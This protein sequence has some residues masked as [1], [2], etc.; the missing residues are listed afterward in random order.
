MGIRHTMCV[1]YAFCIVI[2]SSYFAFCFMYEYNIS[3]CL[4]DQ[5]TDSIVPP[6]IC[7]CLVLCVNL[8]S[9]ISVNYL[10]YFVSTL[11]SQTW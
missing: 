6:C 4:W 2:L 1:N 5:Y 3:H 8:S 9:R 10:S 7:A 11:C